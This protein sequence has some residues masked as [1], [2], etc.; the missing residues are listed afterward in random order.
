MGEAKPAEKAKSAEEAKPTEETTNASS[1]QTPIADEAAG[2]AELMSPSNGGDPLVF[3]P[4][5]RAKLQGLTKA[6]DL[7]G[8]EVIVEGKHEENGRWAVLIGNERMGVKAEN[9][10]MI[11]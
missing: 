4:G 2:A 9:L 5:M 10:L 7:N 8:R 6:Q 11:P 3:Q 1:G